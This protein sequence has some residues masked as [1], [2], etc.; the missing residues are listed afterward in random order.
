MAVSNGQDAPKDLKRHHIARDC[1]EYEAITAA[2]GYGY[3]LLNNVKALE[4]PRC[5]WC[6]NWYG[7]TCEIYQ[8]VREDLH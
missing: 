4:Y 1:E 2:Q 7:G 8:K 5:D 6:V 3:S